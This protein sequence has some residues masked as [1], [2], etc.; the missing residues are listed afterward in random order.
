MSGGGRSACTGGEGTSVEG[1]S[2]PPAGS[3]LLPTASWS[4]SDI[5]CGSR[6]SWGGS[7]VRGVCLRG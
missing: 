6:G 2:S 4:K 5:I 7:A 3:S 1:P